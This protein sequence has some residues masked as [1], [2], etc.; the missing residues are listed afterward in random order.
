MKVTRTD[1]ELL[2]VEGDVRRMEVR[3]SI[4]LEGRWQ[5]PERRLAADYTQGMA[6]EISSYLKGAVA[7]RTRFGIDEKG[8]PLAHH[9]ICNRGGRGEIK[10]SERYTCS[11]NGDASQAVII[12]QST[13][14][15]TFQWDFRLDPATGEVEEIAHDGRGAVVKRTLRKYS[16]E[17]L[18]LHEKRDLGPF[19]DSI[20]S[21][22]DSGMLAEEQRS[23]ERC[24]TFKDYVFD[25]EGNWIQRQKVD[26]D[27]NLDQHYFPPELFY[28]RID[29]ARKGWR[30]GLLGR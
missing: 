8:A 6:T 5:P 12:C 26:Y 23:G 15:P 16:G 4:F 10:G 27:E 17:G 24:L 30:A 7:S 19:R 25:K 21:F 20:F 11:R 22:D 3:S 28:R 14:G 1:S 29:Y 18:L 13:G 2:R 9:A